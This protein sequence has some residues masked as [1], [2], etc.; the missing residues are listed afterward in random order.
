[1]TSGFPAGFAEL[2]TFADWALATERARHHRRRSSTLSET[3]QFYYAMLPV[4]PAALDHLNKFD[5]ETLPQAERSLLCLCL[6]LVEA[7]VAVEMFE[8]VD[9]PYLMTLDRFVPTHDVA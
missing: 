7:A 1:M 8:E 9:P 4:L 2:E 5:L 6:A 3:R